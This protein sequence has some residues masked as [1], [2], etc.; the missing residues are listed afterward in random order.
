[1]KRITAFW[2]GQVASLAMFG[3]L[4]DI[5]GQAGMIEDFRDHWTSAR[6]T[7][8]FEIVA[9]IVAITAWIIAITADE[10]DASR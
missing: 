1:M 6:W 10:Q 7:A 4:Q 9:L 8:P 5:R 3:L 2:F